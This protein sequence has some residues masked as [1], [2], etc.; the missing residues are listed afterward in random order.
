MRL[1]IASTNPGKLRDF[2]HAAKV[3]RHNANAGGEKAEAIEV[4][5]LPGLAGIPAPPEDEPTFEGNASAKAIYYSQYAPA[6]LVLADDSGLEVVCLGNAPGVR[7][8]RYA[9]DVGFPSAPASTADER[10]NAA[11]LRAID[12]VPEHCRQAR[13][14]CVLV[15]AR[16][17]EVV[18]VAEGS[19]EGSIL[20]APRGVGGFGYDPLFFVAEHTQTMAELDPVVRLDINHRGRAFRALI[21]RMSGSASP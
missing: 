4:A 21:Q 20:T 17:G 18:A 16:D 3:Q 9:D 12:G 10:N 14:R 7:S 19:V 15:V 5:P 11:L 13:Y 2:G 1:Y 6:E 8:A